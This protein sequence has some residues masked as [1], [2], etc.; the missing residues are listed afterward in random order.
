MAQD[1]TTG[2]GGEW[3]SEH[4]VLSHFT[5]GRHHD[6]ADRVT[7]AAA[8]GYDGIGLYVGD[9]VR[10]RDADQLGVLDDLL[11][12]H[13]IPLTDIEVLRGWGTVGLADERYAQLEADAWEMA[14][15]FGCRYVQAIGPV[16]ED[17]AEAGRRFGEMC[18]R[19]ADHGL[20]VGLEFLPFTNIVDAD[21][22]RAIVEAAGRENGGLCVDI[23]HHTRGSNDLAQI[24]RIPGEMV[25]GIQMNDGPLLPTNPGDYVDDCLRYRVPPGEGE[26]G[27]VDFVEALLRIGADVPWQMEVCNDAAWEAPGGAHVQASIDG[28]RT[29]LAEARSRMT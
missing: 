12:E 29:V 1:R 7:S 14:D 9:Y 23:W 19:A 2:D 8:A 26:M 13:R 15:R 28:M 4:I 3:T 27:A 21:A 6:I 5:L 24:A 11:A 16:V 22:G 10:L 17:P 18:D 25:T 20:V